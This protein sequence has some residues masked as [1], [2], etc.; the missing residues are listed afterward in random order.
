MTRTDFH[1]LEAQTSNE[2]RQRRIDL[3]QTHMPS[4]PE[5]GEHTD[6]ILEMLGFDAGAGIQT[7]ELEGTRGAYSDAASP[8]ETRT[9]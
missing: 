9:T 5:I 8:L 2:R 6:E 3:H 1:L 7:P 4:S